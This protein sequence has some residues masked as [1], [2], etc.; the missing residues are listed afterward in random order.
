MSTKVGMNGWDRWST[1][2]FLRNKIFPT[3]T[4][5]IHSKQ[6]ILLWAYTICLLGIE[7]HEILWE[8]QTHTSYLIMA[9]RSDVVFIIRQKNSGLWFLPFQ[10]RANKGKRKDRQLLGSGLRDEK[11][12]APESTDYTK[13]LNSLQEPGNWRL[14]E[15]LRPSRLKHFKFVRIFKRVLEICRDSVLIQTPVKKGV[16]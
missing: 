5:S 2:N 6:K 4:N 10:R 3:E 1:E 11:T 9:R 7:K 14:E 16:V 8:F 12:V 13:C 15:E